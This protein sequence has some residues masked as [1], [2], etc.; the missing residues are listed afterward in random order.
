VT[1][2]DIRALFERIRI[3]REREEEPLDHYSICVVISDLSSIPFGRVFD[4]CVE[5]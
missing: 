3:L 2:D 5:L 1:D 4:A